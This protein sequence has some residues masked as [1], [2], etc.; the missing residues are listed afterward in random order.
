MFRSKLTPLL[1]ILLTVPT[2]AGCSAG[3]EQPILDQFFTASRLRDNTTLAGFATVAFEPGTQG[4]VNNFSITNVTPDERKPLTLKTLAKAWDDAR[5]EDAEF[6]KRKYAYA[7]EAGEALERVVKAGRDGTLKG[8]DAEV[9][10]G[11]FKIVDEGVTIAKKITDARRALA[12]QGAVVNLSVSD[13]RKPIDAS[14]YDGELVSKDVTIDAPVKLPSG[15]TVQKT[16]LVTMQRA[17]LKAEKP[18]VGRWI[19]T[20]IR[21]ASGAPATPRS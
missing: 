10:A 1:A 18:I 5:A 19:I 4:I 14:K 3:P 2:V 11:W 9:Q 16:L 17:E 7:G 8:K 6:N 20:N 15:Q 13:P 12:A 21:D